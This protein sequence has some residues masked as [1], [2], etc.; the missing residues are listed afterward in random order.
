MRILPVR[1]EFNEL[2]GVM[3]EE[4]PL[5]FAEYSGNDT[6]VWG[7]WLLLVRSTLVMSLSTLPKTEPMGT[8]FFDPSAWL[9]EGKLVSSNK[10]LVLFLVFWFFCC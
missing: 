1:V 7:V 10:R 2:I 4:L 8:K 5:L 3:G 6:G 9:C